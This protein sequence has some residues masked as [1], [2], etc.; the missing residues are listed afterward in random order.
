MF[1]EENSS[2]GFHITKRSLITVLACVAV[3]MLLMRTGFLT[4]F[5]LVPLGF[6]VF[7]CGSYMFTFASAAAVNLII[8][9]ISAAVV[10]GNDLNFL[11]MLIDISYLTALM[12]LFTWV[13]GGRNIR[14]AYRIILASSIS[15][16]FFIIMINRLDSL[17][18]TYSMEVAQELMPGIVTA[19]MIEFARNVL[20]RGGALISMFFVFFINRQI[21]SSI[22]WLVKKQ[23]KDRGLIAFYAP[24]NT[25]WVFSGSLA[26]VILAN[27]FGIE[28][29]EII[30]WNIFVI[31]VIIFMAQGI[32]IL[33]HLLS[34]KSSVFRICSVVFFVILLFSPLIVI[35][36]AAVL[37][38]GII[39]IWRPFRRN[40][41]HL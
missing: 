11:N 17:F 36:V 13:T 22:F 26:T 19:E 2:P 25:I 31:C 12:F 4:V 18:Y 23:R 8:Y 16:I 27:I 33:S 34:G 28:F 6:A 9:I 38:L 14:T 10:S 15:T 41:D 32:G 5:F 3:S 37:V 7:S 29:L 20:L 39:E 40:V 1:Q 30:A 24:D 35:A 21:A